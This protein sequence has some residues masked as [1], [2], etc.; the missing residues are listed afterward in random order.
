MYFTPRSSYRVRRYRH[1]DRFSSSVSPRLLT[2]EGIT[3][4]EDYWLSYGG[5]E[6]LAVRKTLGCCDISKTHLHVFFGGEGYAHGP[7]SN[8]VHGGDRR[9]SQN[10]GSLE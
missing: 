9:R 4:D 5:G 10:N 3:S 7:Y 6:A 1:T 8:T 2:L